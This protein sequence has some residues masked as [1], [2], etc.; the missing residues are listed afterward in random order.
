M[1]SYFVT[2][3]ESYETKIS[4]YYG[5]SSGSSLHTALSDS[6]CVRSTPA[7]MGTQSLATFSHLRTDHTLLAKFLCSAVAN[8]K[9][10]PSGV[11]VAPELRINNSWGNVK[12]RNLTDKWLEPQSLPKAV[13]WATCVEITGSY[14]ALF[15]A[16][17]SSASPANCFLQSP[18]S[19]NILSSLSV[20][21][22]LSFWAYLKVEYFLLANDYFKR[23]K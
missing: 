9:L 10:C 5:V 20:F 16:K 7:R 23:K 18:V 6:W 2:W 12:S 1:A 19:L 3:C 4:C 11:L 13:S 17:L 14:I 15:R 22:P 21:F 8:S